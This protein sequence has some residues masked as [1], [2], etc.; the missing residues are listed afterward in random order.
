MQA[1]SPTAPWRRAEYSSAALRGEHPKP[2]GNVNTAIIL[3]DAEVIVVNKDRT[4]IN[5][6]IHVVTSY[7]AS[8]VNVVA[9]ELAVIAKNNTSI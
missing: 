8:T 4:L 6:D 2:N 1:R 7:A 5:A 9:P 3:G